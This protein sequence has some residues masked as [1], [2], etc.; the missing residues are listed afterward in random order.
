M[1]KQTF[2]LHPRPLPVEPREGTRW[3]GLPEIW[4]F[5]SEYLLLLPCRGGRARVGQH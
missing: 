2:Y 1:S 4:H 5:V 3:R